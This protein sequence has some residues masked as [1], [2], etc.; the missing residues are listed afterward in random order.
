MIFGKKLYIKINDFITK[1]VM[2]LIFGYVRVSAKDQNPARQI[3]ILIDMGI[4]ERN[5]YLEKESGRKFERP[6]YRS[7]V[8]NILREGDL[9]VVTELKRFG[10]NYSEIYKEWFHITKEIG[11]DIKVTSMPI[12]DTTQSKELVGQL[13]T[14]VVLAVFAYVAD[15]DWTERHELQRQ[16]IEV[17]KANGRHLGRPRVEYP[18]NWEDCYGRW[19]SGVISA[20]EAMTLTALKKDSFYRLVKKYEAELKKTQEETV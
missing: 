10:R 8:D 14:D 11:A 9:L 7:L 13:I 6:V 5:I 16:G 15:E 4:E 20:K 19:K 12:L 2:S 18:E 1:E 3:K 17:A